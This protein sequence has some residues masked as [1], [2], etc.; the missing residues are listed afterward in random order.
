M[1][2]ELLQIRIE[3][4]LKQGLKDVLKYKRLTI[5]DWIRSKIELEI[6]NNKIII[7]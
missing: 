1:T 6:R 2:T 4:E 3:S 5:S 7:E